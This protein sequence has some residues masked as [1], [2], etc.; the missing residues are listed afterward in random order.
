MKLYIIHETAVGKISKQAKT[1]LNNIIGKVVADEEA[2]YEHVI[3][4]A[5]NID[6]S[7]IQDEKWWEELFVLLDPIPRDVLEKCLQK[8]IQHI[9]DELKK[10]NKN[11]SIPLVG[12]LAIEGILGSLVELLKRAALAAINTMIAALSN[13][14]HGGYGGG[15]GGHGGYSR[16]TSGSLKRREKIGAINA[17]AVTHFIGQVEPIAEIM[18]RKK[19]KEQ[20]AAEAAEQAAK[21]TKKTKQPQKPR[22]TEMQR[23]RQHWPTS[24]SVEA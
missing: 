8:T 13:S 4:G 7:T 23:R 21:P 19:E 24:E 10:I 2:L 6:G 9:E 3:K 14:G 11:S 22:P 16:R 1:A 5:S 20:E 17:M 15:Y 18:L 12:G